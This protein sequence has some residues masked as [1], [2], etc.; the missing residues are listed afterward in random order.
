MGVARTVL[1][2]ELGRSAQQCQYEGGRYERYAKPHKNLGM[3]SEG[4]W[5]LRARFELK[6][7]VLL[8]DMAFKASEI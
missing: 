8:S 7:V 1:Y 5:D 3:Y 2:K 6:S 4:L